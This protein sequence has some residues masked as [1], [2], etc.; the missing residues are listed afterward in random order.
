MTMTPYDFAMLTGIEIG[1]HFR[2]TEPGTLE[3]IEQYTRGFLMFLF[4][5]TLF[6]DRANTVGLYLL[7]ALVDLSRVRLYDWGGAG[8]ATLYG[9][10]SSTSCRSG[11]RVGGY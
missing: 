9:Y 10:M 7:S 2:G 4:G 1:D 8:L 6:P 3:E 5:T 11:N